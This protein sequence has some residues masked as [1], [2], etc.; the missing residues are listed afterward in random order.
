MSEIT[1]V[2]GASAGIG[3]ALARECARRRWSLML[4]ARRR[5]RLEA[6]AEE[7]RSEHGIEVHVEPADL[8]RSE[9]PGALLDAVESAGLIVGGLINNAGFGQRGEVADIGTER[10]TQMV[11]LNVR[12]LTELTA[13]V[14]PGMKARRRGRILNVASTAAFQPGPYMAVYYATKAYVL[15]FTEAVHEEARPYGVHVSAL[16]PGPTDSEFAAEAGMEDIVFF[17]RG[18]TA[19]SENVAETGIEGL[20]KNR[21]VNVSGAMNKVMAGGIRFTPR[22]LARR[23]AG[24]LQSRS[25]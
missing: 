7:L 2:T 13:R 16:C 19:S 6:L 23:I 9:G 24:Q 17:K 1:I 25:N 12:A 20:V 10:Q 22:A 8:S 5:D 21:A 14:L 18:F 15:S 11:D 4:T 3:A